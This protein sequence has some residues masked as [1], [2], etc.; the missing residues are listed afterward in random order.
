[1]KTDR[2]VWYVADPM[3]S[4]CWGFSSVIDAIA[5]A[6]RDRVPVRLVM[7]GLRPGTVKPITP[8]ERDEI[9]HHWHE[10]QRRTGQVF[11][12]EDAMPEDRRKS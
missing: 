1:M 11:L 2:I 5:Q 6:Y 7:G 8:E 9:L 3:C 10:V 4:W 12:F